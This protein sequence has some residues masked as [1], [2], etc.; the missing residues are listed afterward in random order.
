MDFEVLGRIGFLD[1]C[2]DGGFSGRHKA[3]GIRQEGRNPN[4]VSYHVVD[5]SFDRFFRQLMCQCSI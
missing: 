1:G 3:R 4:T 2:V 5:T